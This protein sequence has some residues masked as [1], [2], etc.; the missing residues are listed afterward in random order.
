MVFNQYN[1]ND[2]NLLKFTENSADEVC[3]RVISGNDENNPANM[4]IRDTGGNPAEIDDTTHTLQN[5]EYEHHEIHSGSHYFIC[6]YDSSI[7][8]SET[9]EFV[10]T[11]SDTT[12]WAHMVLDFSSTLGVS[13]EVY[14]GSTDVVGG[15]SVTPINN[16]RNSTNTSSLTIVKDPTSI[17][18]G[19]RIAGFLAG[20]NRQSGFNNRER[21]VILKQNTTYLFRFTSLANNNAV[22]FCGEWYEHT[23]K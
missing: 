12:K 1:L 16:N 14:E 19:T 6:D 21:E 22:S 9:I 15:T 2:N 5:I 10:I 13:L 11:T 7:Q 23:N 17:T 18:D 8:V 4:I 3:V 20:A